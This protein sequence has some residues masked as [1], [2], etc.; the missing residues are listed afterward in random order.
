ML[1][2]EKKGL[3]AFNGLELYGNGV[4]YAK[5]SGDICLP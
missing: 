1:E 4:M 2:Y 5:G 3:A